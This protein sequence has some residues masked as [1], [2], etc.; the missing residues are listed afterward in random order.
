M[1][2]FIPENPTVNLLVIDGQIRAR[3]N[4]IGRDLTV[5][6]TD[7]PVEFADQALNKPFDSTKP[8]QA[9]Q[10]LAHRK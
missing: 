4:N 5:T 3:A 6:I 8:V 7:S 10:V 2:A 9:A 1:N